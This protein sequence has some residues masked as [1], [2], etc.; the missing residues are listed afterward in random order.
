MVTVV[1]TVASPVSLLA[2]VTVNALVVSVLRETVPV[3]V[4]PSSET[5]DARMDTVRLAASSSETSTVSVPL[6]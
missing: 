1:G 4:P 5:D 6:S 3:V 2:S